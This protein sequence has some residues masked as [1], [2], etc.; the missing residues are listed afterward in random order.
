VTAWKAP[1]EW[2]FVALS[3]R[4]YSAG[5]G[6]IVALYHRVASHGAVLRLV[7]NP[8]SMVRRVLQITRIDELIPFYSDRDEA[9]Q[10]Q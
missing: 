3:R 7:V 10:G 6:S 9:V 5:I 2:E 1:T 4:V 8:D